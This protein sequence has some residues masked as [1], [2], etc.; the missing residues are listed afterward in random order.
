MPVEATVR[1]VCLNVFS[2]HAL[3]PTRQILSARHT[4]PPTPTSAP[5]SSRRTAGPHT[6]PAHHPESGPTCS[7]GHMIYP[8][9]VSA[10]TRRIE[11]AVPILKPPLLDLRVP[12]PVSLSR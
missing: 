6:L 4:N 10:R 5:I 2:A 9:G 12:G 3:P 7:R 1:A 8:A 11:A